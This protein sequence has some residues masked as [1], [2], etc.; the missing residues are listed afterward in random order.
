MEEE[1]QEQPERKEIVEMLA[2]S[3]LSRRAEAMEYRAS[4]GVERCWAEDEES[5]DFMDDV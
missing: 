3:L 1:K 2:S 4:T 5:F